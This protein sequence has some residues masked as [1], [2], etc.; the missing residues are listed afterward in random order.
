[1][2]GKAALP[3]NADNIR[4][5]AGNVPISRMNLGQVDRSGCKDH[6]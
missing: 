4:G 1:M 3:L 2:A 5:Q 6:T